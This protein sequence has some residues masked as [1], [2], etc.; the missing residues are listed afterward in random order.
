MIE[1]RKHLTH[2]RL[3]ELMSYDPQTGIL[4]W[5]FSKRGIKAGADVGSQNSKGYLCATVEGER[6]LNHR[7]AWF[8]I[9][10]KWPV[11]LIDHR[12]TDKKNNRF[13]NLREATGS[14][15]LANRGPTARNR[16]G[17]KG[18]CWH[19]L[20]SKWEAKIKVG[21]K[22]HHIGLFKTKQD[23][24]AAYNAAA[25]EYFGEFARVA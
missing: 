15:N 20:T 2:Q 17:H 12:D 6:F 5:R 21:K 9:T 23:A 19:R 7:L 4:K 13:A 22:N 8:Y 25:I 18:V 3:L 11:G 24:C 16:S 10:G 1:A 14:Q